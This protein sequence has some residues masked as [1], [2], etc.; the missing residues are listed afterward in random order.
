MKLATVLAVVC[1]PPRS[2]LLYEPGRFIPEGCR[3]ATGWPHLMLR[4]P[5]GGRRADHY[6]RVSSSG[7][8]PDIGSVDEMHDGLAAASADHIVYS[9]TSLPQQQQQQQLHD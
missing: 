8:P 7:R 6:G 1:P 5:D 9:P 4:G 3:E 2:P